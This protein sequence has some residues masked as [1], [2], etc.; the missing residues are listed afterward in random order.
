MNA[1]EHNQQELEQQ[2]MTF[3]RI[4]TE[5]NA[6]KG[7]YNSFGKYNYRSCEDI[8]H[9]LKPLLAEAGFTLVITDEIVMVGS[10]YY[11][12][13]T[14]T[15]R[16]GGGKVIAEN[17]AYAREAEAK[18]GMDESQI[19]GTASSYARKYAL[20]G[21]LMIDDTKDA[22]TDENAKVKKEAATPRVP[23]DKQLADNLEAMEAS[24]NL[25][26]LKILARA[27]TDYFTKW[28]QPK[29][30]AQIKAKYDQIAATFEAGEKVDQE[31]AA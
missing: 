17:K 11:L 20:N 23:H 27:A 3:Q 25:P 9:A 18:K 29:A 31:K 15:I 5:L 14:C 26:M 19:T 7:Q 1:D 21:L 2:A 6:P 8:L 4:Q 16:D 30:C 24:T 12:Q 13:A 22:D 10:R 28:E